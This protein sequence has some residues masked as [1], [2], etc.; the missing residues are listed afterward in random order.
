MKGSRTSQSSGNFSPILR[1]WG[2]QSIPSLMGEAMGL[3]YSHP[4]LPKKLATGKR[5][6]FSDSNILT[7]L[8]TTTN[9][10]LEP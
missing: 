1:R 5:T 8:K 7:F 2:Y 6:S 3:V 4:L 10:L 9:L